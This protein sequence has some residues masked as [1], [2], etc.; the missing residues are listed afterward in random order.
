[1]KISKFTCINNLILLTVLFCAFSNCVYG[2]NSIVDN[3]IELS[4]N[5][6]IVLLGETNHGISEEYEL[7]SKYTTKRFEHESELIFFSESS[8]C[9]SYVAHKKNGG[10][11]F[12]T[13]SFIYRESEEMDSLV[14][15]AIR[16]NR[17]HYGFDPQVIGLTQ[18]DILFIVSQFTSE[19]AKVEILTEAIRNLNA[20]VELSQNM[21]DVI[22]KLLLN[23]KRILEKQ[24]LKNLLWASDVKKNFNGLNEETFKAKDANLRDS[25]M[26]QNFIFL[27]RFLGEKPIISIGAS[28]HLAYGTFSIENEELKEFFPMGSHLRQQ[29]AKGEICNIAFSNKQGTSKALQDVKMHDLPASPE[30]F[31]SKLSEY[32][33]IVKSEGVN[34]KPSLVFGEQLLIGNWSDIIDYFVVHESVKPISPTKVEGKLVKIQKSKSFVFLDAKTGE[35]IPFAHIY[36]PEI[37]EGMT[38]NEQG[39]ANLKNLNNKEKIQFV[40]HSL[41]YEKLEATLLTSQLEESQIVIKLKPM[42]GM[43]NEVVINAESQTPVTYLAKMRKAMS[44]TKQMPV[45]NYYHTIS[46]AYDQKDSIDCETINQV[47]YE[48][49]R[50]KNPDIDILA[51][52]ALDEKKYKKYKRALSFPGMALGHTDLFLKSIYKENLNKIVKKNTL[53]VQYVD[54]LNSFRIDFYSENSN[55][56]FSVKHTC[57]GFI[58]I[59][60][61]DMLPS[62][63]ISTYS[64]NKFNYVFDF[65]ASYSMINGYLTTTFSK[66]KL[67]WTKHKDLD[68]RIGT[69]EAKSAWTKQINPESNE[70]IYQTTHDLENFDYNKND[71]EKFSEYTMEK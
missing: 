59:N 51:R 19:P 65:E 11:D 26:A 53:S 44:E 34:G 38:A 13:L 54:S 7:I 21:E 55:L 24:L 66:E 3:L 14:K 15:Y 57:K 1:M 58:I 42:A 8:F 60:A 46:K 35:Y 61:V 52:K 9:E 18:E 30:A 23:E 43:L 32:P 20:D 33:Q 36:F 62:Y 12:S 25:L 10:S 31:E 70:K 6:R 4:Q 47:Y 2:Y 50:D 69:V 48:N 28:L 64:F 5:S 68:W 17:L 41:G 16:E 49:S 45:I 22:K 27:D 71:W 39:R 63:Y 67:D 29:Y 37:K 56:D 40:A